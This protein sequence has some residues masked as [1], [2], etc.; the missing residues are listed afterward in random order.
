MSFAQISDIEDEARQDTINV[1]GTSSDLALGAPAGFLET[2]MSIS[3]VDAETLL[4]QGGTELLDGLR[5]VPG[6]Q[7]DLSFVGSHSQVFV[8]RGSIADNGTQASRILRDGA[9][10][11]NYGFTPAFVERL[12]VIRGP[13]A[14]AAVRTEPGGT[15]EVVTKSAQM[16]DFGSAYVRI[17]ENNAQEYWLDVNRVLS[18]Q[19][20]IAARAIAARSVADEWRNAPDKLDGIKLNL[21]KTE[22]DAYR[23]S[24]DFEGTNQDY[25]PDFGLPGLNGAPAAVPLD[26]Q[27]SE[28]FADSET[29]NRIFSAHGEFKLSP[30]T[31]LSV[32]YT[33][34]DSSTLSIRNS[35]FRE[36]AGPT[37]TFMRVTA[38]EPDGN[39]DIDALSASIISVFKAGKVTHNLFVG[40]EYYL[41]KATIPR[42][43][44]PASNNPP[45]NVFNPVYGLTTAPSG[46]FSPTFTTQDSESYL[47]TVQ[48]RIEIGRF[49]LIA[50]LQYVDD[51]SLYGGAGTLPYS[52]DRLSPKVGVTYAVTPNQSLYASYTTGTSPQYV[53]TATRESVPMRTS[54]QIE[55]GWKAELFDGRV[56]AE[57]AAYR[58][59]QDRTITPDPNQFGVFFVNGSTRSQGLE[60]ALNGQLTDRLSLGLSYAYT[61][62]EFLEGSLSPGNQTPNVPYNSGNAFVEMQWDDHWR[63]SL[64]VYAQGDRFADLANTTVLDGYVTADLAQAYAFELAG[65][66]VEL[67]L[68]IRNLFDETYYSGSHLHVSR[69]IMPGRPR[70]VSLSAMFRF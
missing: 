2:P 8:I 59:E 42:V 10:L 39:R 41:E 28:P 23:I 54:D 65:N 27:L 64:N 24:F 16:D 40:A 26:R 33:H 68:N 36:I 21:T 38:F 63:S 44:V 45:I 4:N 17:G 1:T 58:L 5:N 12:N 3:T 62:A 66:D 32:D 19:H 67:Q 25:Q 56:Q 35:V 53:A 15:V 9:R 20:G 18:E 22:G 43:A 13:G 31:D 11:T 49:N 29:D 50:G 7:A 51:T 30:S 69:Y 52:E 6:I 14:A 48:D 55:A 57:L 37:G 70:T 46:P 61:D 34:M 47:L 60:A